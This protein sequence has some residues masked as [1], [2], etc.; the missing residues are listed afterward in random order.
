MDA[1]DFCPSIQVFDRP[2]SVG[3]AHAEGI[4]DLFY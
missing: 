4:R 1:S 2:P 3:V